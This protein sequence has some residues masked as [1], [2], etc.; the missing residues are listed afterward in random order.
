MCIICDGRSFEEA[1]RGID[2]SI[3][4]YGWHLV[5]VD[6]A[7]GWSYTIGLTETFNHPELVVVDLKLE[8]G[9]KLVAMAVHLIE[10]DGY[11]KPEELAKH[12]ISVVTVH[13]HHLDGEW[14]GRW[15]DHYNADPSSGSFLQIIPPA[16]CFCEDHKDTTRRLDRADAM[17]LANRA[18]RRQA[19]RKRRPPD[20]R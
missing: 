13:D 12:G 17:P 6:D 3:R 16:E 18:T 8:T 19:S 11:L 9:K 7:M 14:F 1:A 15:S 2:L 20:H 5:M 10:R 4:I